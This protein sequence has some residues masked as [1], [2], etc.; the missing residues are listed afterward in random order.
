MKKPEILNVRRIPSNVPTSPL[1]VLV[2]RQIGLP[3]SLRR[4]LA[5]CDDGGWR[6]RL[7]TTLPPSSQIV[8]TLATTLATTKR[9][10]IRIATEATNRLEIL[11]RSVSRL[12]LPYYRKGSRI[13]LTSE[14]HNDYLPRLQT[15]SIMFCELISHLIRMTP[16]DSS[17]VTAIELLSTTDPP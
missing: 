5:P 12:D 2:W 1:T 15:G 13:L 6:S 7:V 16:L 11:R 14:H 10:L 3:R 8:S 9:T 17:Q 4:A